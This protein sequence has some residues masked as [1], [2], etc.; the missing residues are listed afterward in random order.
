MEE[1]TH[2]PGIPTVLQRCAVAHA[3]DEIVRYLDELHKSGSPLEYKSI[4]CGKP[5]TVQKLHLWQGAW[6]SATDPQDELAIW[7]T[8]CDTH[9]EMLGLEQLVSGPSVE[10]ESGPG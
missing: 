5:G 7:T 3:H 2:E 4:M 1:V 8:I 6:E 10:P 9:A